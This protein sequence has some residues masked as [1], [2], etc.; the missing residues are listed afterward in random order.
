[1]SGD[2]TDD[3][4]PKRPGAPLPVVNDV[5]APAAPAAWYRAASRTEV[6]T[7]R[8][9]RVKLAERWVA[10]IWWRERVHAID[11]RCPHRGSS[12]AVGIVEHD[13]YV[14]CLDHGWE[15]SLVSGCGRVG[16][17]GCAQVFE[18]EDRDGEVWV[19]VAP[20]PMPAW[21]EGWPDDED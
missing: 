20:R 13:G 8:G 1:M 21:A 10:L 19:K 16:Y 5:L 3:E 15:Y 11:D 12:L 18:V 6:E 4:T 17:E 14:A 9:M 7:A 2:G